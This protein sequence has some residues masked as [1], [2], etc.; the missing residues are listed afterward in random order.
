MT[1]LVTSLSALFFSIVLLVSGNAFLMT[2]LGLRLSIAQIS[3]SLIGWILVCYSVGFVF[4]T[5]YAPRVVTRVGHI[6]SFSVFAAIAAVAALA[7]PVFFSAGFWAVLRAA[8]GFSMAGLLIVIESWFSSRAANHNRGALFAVYQIV[9]Y[10]SSAGGQLLVNVGDPGRFVPFSL[11]AMLLTLALIPLALT[12][13][14]APSLEEHERLSFLDLYR[15]SSTGVVGA[16]ICGV[17]IGSFYAM[18][19]VYGHMTGLSLGQISLFMA[20]AIVAAMLFAWPIGRVCDLRDRRWV[21]F[22]ITVAAGISST[23]A[24]V[25]GNQ[26]L[27]FLVLS[28]GTFVGLSAAIYPVAVAITN[29]RMESTRIVAASSSLLLSYGLGSCIGPVL[30]A[31]ILQWLGPPGLF[32]GDTLV[33]ALLAGLTLYRI[34]S[35]PD[36][37]VAA[38]EEFVTS[39]PEGT[40]VLTEMDPR[41][42]G[43]TPAPDDSEVAGPYSSPRA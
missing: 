21:M 19:P 24:A 33:L 36:V 22:W 14:E 9:Y 28:A 15:E 8:S 29:D 23:L 18:G 42:S 37:P 1:R 43:F 34:H 41:N 2:L 4:G 13:M 30:G 40:P 6:R 20:S 38:Q 12:R 17:V 39:L 26:G 5:L 3:P 16:L 7:H 31:N 27:T 10:L 35:T 32:L 25:L 11:A